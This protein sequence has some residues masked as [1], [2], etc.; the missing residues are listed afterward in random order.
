MSYESLPTTE[1]RMVTIKNLNESSSY[2][3]FNYI[4]QDTLVESSNHGVD[5]MRSEEQEENQQ[6]QIYRIFDTNIVQSKNSTYDG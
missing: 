2:I 1:H 3:R 5:W 6:I 4:G